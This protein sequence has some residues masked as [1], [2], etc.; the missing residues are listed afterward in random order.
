LVRSTFSE[1]K[2][3]SIAACPVARWLMLQ[4]IPLGHQALELLAGVLE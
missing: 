1:E 2:K 3:L 4:T